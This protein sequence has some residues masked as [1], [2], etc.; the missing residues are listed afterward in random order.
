MALGNVRF[1][2]QRTL[3]RG[4]ATSVL[5]LIALRNSAAFC[6]WAGLS[7]G[8]L[9]RYPLRGFNSVIG[10]TRLIE[11][12]RRTRDCARRRRAAEQLDEAPQVLS[13]CG[14]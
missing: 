5:T 14:Q 7:V 12:L 10:Y 1:S 8:A 13:G 3:G 2:Q 6:S 9:R 4:R 11:R